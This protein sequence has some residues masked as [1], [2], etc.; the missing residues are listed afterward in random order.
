MSDTPGPG[1]YQ[2]GPA[3]PSGQADP[4]GWASP[5]AQSTPFG[6]QAAYGQGTPYGE[7]WTP[8]ASFPQPTDDA[9]P[10]IMSFAPAMKQNRLT[11]FFR[12]IMAIP[13]TF[14]VGVIGIAAYF[15]GIIGWWAA[16]FMGTLPP[17]AFEFQSGFLR[18]SARVQAY[19]YLLTDVYPPFSLEDADYPVR[20]FTR[21]TRLNR[22]AV[23]FRVILIIPAYLLALISGFGLVILGFVA[24]LT[25]LF[26]GKLPDSLHEAL[27][28]FIRY[29]TR[30]TGYW[31]LVTPEY[32]GGLYGDKIAAAPAA[33]WTAP[34]AASG[35]TAPITGAGPA[36]AGPW[37]LVLS[38]TAR[39]LVTVGLVLGVIG[40]AGDAVVTATLLGHAVS[41]GNRVI[42]N[43]NVTDDYN[44][45]GTVITSFQ[46]KTEACQQNISCITALDTQVAKAFQTF[47]TGLAGA[48]VPS[49]F[50]A[51][52]ATLTADNTKVAGDFNQLAGAQSASQYTSIATGLDLQSDLTA[53]QSA[54]NKLHGE[55]N[56]P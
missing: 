43:Q 40:V 1:E 23:L 32:P 53:W 42:A 17:W 29:Y 44:K 20:L 21:Q 25:A 37:Q 2:P 11:V 31:L 46:T 22:L 28:A 51:D 34:D 50:S 10:V 52:A 9:A 3:E 41:T 24:W 15:V 56:K 54:F 49:A 19:T 45:L 27:A 35:D 38:G 39:N 6:E 47:G 8:T 5:S 36:S 30:F 14:V 13:A 7:Q 33:E 12:L 48:G 26:A 18:W 55:L 4:P 16:L